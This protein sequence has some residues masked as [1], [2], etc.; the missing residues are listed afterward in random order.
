[1]TDEKINTPDI[2][3][4]IP[5][6]IDELSPR[7][8]DERGKSPIRFYQFLSELKDEITDILTELKKPIPVRNNTLIK[9]AF[10]SLPKEIV[11]S[12]SECKDVG[13]I[14][15]L[16][17][18]Y[19]PR[20]GYLP[21]ESRAAFI[22]AL[23]SQFPKLLHLATVLP[24]KVGRKPETDTT[25]VMGDY[26]LR[27]PEYKE[28]LFQRLLKTEGRGKKFAELR[29]EFAEHVFGKSWED[30]KDVSRR[31]LYGRYKSLNATRFKSRRTKF[32]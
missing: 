3:P 2:K 19:D 28:S 27:N 11:D 7:L 17:H 1:M 9:A 20:L 13:S 4:P 5:L 21:A 25:R 16:L 32:K 31:F 18:R 23:A 29:D 24:Q 26:L 22:D 14:V 15:Y 6:N 30:F 12:L 8:W 10:K